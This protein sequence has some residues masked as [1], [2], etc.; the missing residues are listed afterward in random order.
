MKTLILFF[1]VSLL[2]GTASWAVPQDASFTGEI[3]DSQ[4]AQMGS[5][6]T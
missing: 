5:H 6:E 3:M 2:F 1:A 4:C